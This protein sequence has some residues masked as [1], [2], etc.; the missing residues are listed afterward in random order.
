[1]VHFRASVDPEAR[2]SL[3]LLVKDSS[4]EI[5]GSKRR[6]PGGNRGHFRLVERLSYNVGRL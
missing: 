4:P 5:K 1:M 3:N 6:D 2:M